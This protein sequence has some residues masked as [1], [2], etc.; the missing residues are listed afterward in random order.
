M[1]GFD[2]VFNLEHNR[3]VRTDGFLRIHPFGEPS[4]IPLTPFGKLMT[5]FD[6]LRAN[7]IMEGLAA[8]FRKNGLS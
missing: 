4:I 3:R 5:G 1:I 8:L 7:G 2:K 6:R